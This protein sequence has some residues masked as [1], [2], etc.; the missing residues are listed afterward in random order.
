MFETDYVFSND[1]IKLEDVNPKKNSPVCDLISPEGT[2]HSQYA[3]I[4]ELGAIKK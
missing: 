3:P 2:K 4:T 1:F